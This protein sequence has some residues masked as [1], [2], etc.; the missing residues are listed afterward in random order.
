MNI[1]TYLA[2]RFALFISAGAIL[3]LLRYTGKSIV[4]SVDKKDWNKTHNIF[5]K[6][7]KQKGV[8]NE[9]IMQLTDVLDNNYKAIL[10]LDG[11]GGLNPQSY[12]NNNGHS[13]KNNDNDN[14]E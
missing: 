14:D 1:I 6:Q 11:D 9:H 8:S 4:F 5:E 12:H 7:L 2:L 10:G 13:S 3:F